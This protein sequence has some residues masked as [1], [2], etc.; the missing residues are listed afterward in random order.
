M[1]KICDIRK[2]IKES[3]VVLLSAMHQLEIPFEL[4]ESEKSRDFI[5]KDAGNPDVHITNVSLLPRKHALKMSEFF[6]Q[7]KFSS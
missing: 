3:I 6:H 2:N 1:E 7:R 4:A 5:L